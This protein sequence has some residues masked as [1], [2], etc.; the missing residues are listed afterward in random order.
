MAVEEEEAEY[1][2]DPEDTPLPSMRR[3][4]AS[5][6]EDGEG[7]DCGEVARKDQRAGMV[8]EGESDGQREAEVYDDEDDLEEEELEQAME[9]EEE[10]AEHEECV[11]VEGRI[12]VNVREGLELVGKQF[13]DR[14]DQVEEEK[15]EN[16]P[17]DVPT[18]GAFY[19]H[20]DR[21]QSNGRGRHR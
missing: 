1:E 20:D 17:Y 16:E 15:K 18:N 21:F 8:S 14:K 11:G 6:D 4:E 13:G 7:S 19:M 3:R 12:H 2:S 9:G 10:E 5:D